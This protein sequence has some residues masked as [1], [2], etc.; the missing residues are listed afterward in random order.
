[1]LKAAWPGTEF[2]KI[3]DPVACAGVHFTVGLTV[4]ETYCCFP[5]TRVFGTIRI[6]SLC[7]AQIIL[8]TYYFIKLIGKQ[9]QDIK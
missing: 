6:N 9:M 5:G 1:M 2:C 3:F 7:L 8:G 4:S